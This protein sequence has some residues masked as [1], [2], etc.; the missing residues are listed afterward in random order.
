LPPRF[1]G[2]TV[3][4]AAAGGILYRYQ[5]DTPL[6]GVCACNRRPPKP[7]ELVSDALIF[8]D[9]VEHGDARDGAGIR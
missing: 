5:Y 1:P 2:S 6:I 8:V 9:D 7:R 4:L 3:I